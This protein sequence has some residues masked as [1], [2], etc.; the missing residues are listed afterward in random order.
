MSCRGFFIFFLREVETSLPALPGKLE[1]LPSGAESYLEVILPR[2]GVSPHSLAL[3][4]LVKLRFPAVESFLV[5]K[6]GTE[7]SRLCQ[8]DLWLEMNANPWVV[9]LDP[10]LFLLH[11]GMQPLC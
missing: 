6:E 7:D 2:C 1:V 5:F 3:S 4:V 11:I 8:R 10:S 9:I